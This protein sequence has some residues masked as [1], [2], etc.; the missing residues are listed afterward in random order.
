MLAAPAFERCGATWLNGILG[1]SI[2]EGVDTA[3]LIPPVYILT[4]MLF[5]DVTSRA[6]VRRAVG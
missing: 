3:R 1:N 5:S 4:T 2:F 6:V